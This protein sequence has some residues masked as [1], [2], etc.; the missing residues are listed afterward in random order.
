MNA[1][2]NLLKGLAFQLLS[3]SRY[4]GKMFLKH[5]E[6]FPQI[7]PADPEIRNRLYIKQS[8]RDELYHLYQKN[9]SFKSIVN[10][11][12]R[13]RLHDDI[14]KIK[15]VLQAAIFMN[16]NFFFQINAKTGMGKSMIA[17]D[18]IIPYF[19][20]L[21]RSNFRVYCNIDDL[22]NFFL[23]D[24]GDYMLRHGKIS[25]QDKEKFDKN[26]CINV[27]VTYDNSQT[28]KVLMMDSKPNDI[29]FQD[30]APKQ[31][32]K[33]SL[34][35]V[36]N[37]ENLIKSVN[38]AMNRN[39]IICTPEFIPF[40]E[41]DYTLQVIGF[42]ANKKRSLVAIRTKTGDYTGMAFVNLL[43]LAD[44]DRYYERESRKQKQKL[45][46]DG[47]FSVYYINEERMKMLKQQLKEKVMEFVEKTGTNITKSLIEALALYTDVN[48]E[49][50]KKEIITLVYHELKAEQE[51][52]KHEKGAFQDEQHDDGENADID[53]VQ[54]GSIV[55]NGKIMKFHLVTRED[56]M[57]YLKGYKNKR[58]VDL[59]LESLTRTYDEIAIE[60]DLSQTMVSRIVQKVR[61]WLM[62]EMGR[63]FEIVVKKEYE[64]KD[65]ISKV[66]HD[67]NPGKTDLT[68]FYKN[69]TV[70]FI[71]AKWRNPSINRPNM[72]INVKELNAEIFDA[73]KYFKAHP[74]AKDKIRVTMYVF[75][76][77]TGKKYV[78]PV[79]WENP[80][81][82]Y[83]ISNQ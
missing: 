32:S 37:L 29:I 66:V 73:K 41:I 57:A 3:Q 5:D 45:L 38:R 21:N 2:S 31:H 43:D 53:N 60:H 28:N 67:G 20:L 51:L 46:K 64:S 78:V 27:Y 33:G 56:Y 22:D 47:G 26:E 18:Y 7:S 77:T 50:M 9:D 82:N 15:F 44:L 39:V 13:K 74:D 79:N 23:V 58:E 10:R 1:R 72:S 42:I 69:G 61:K 55:V 68:C 8:Y 75:N 70:E 49:I 80:L 6:F 11:L 4:V 48:K 16:S 14:E 63:V 19:C 83:K 36:D 24:L 12:Y 17:R 35:S 25:K 54:D 76:N 71:N 59:Y 52:A 30:E 40:S 62:Q 65:D 34:I 81:R